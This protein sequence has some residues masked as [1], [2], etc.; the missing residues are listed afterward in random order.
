MREAEIRGE[1][2]GKEIL[3]TRQGDSHDK[4]AG[5]RGSARAAGVR[6]HG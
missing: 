2:L 6:R 1:K 3:M 5:P 4:D